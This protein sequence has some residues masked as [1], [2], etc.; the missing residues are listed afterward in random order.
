LHDTAIM[1]R[2]RRVLL[3]THAAETLDEE[4]YCEDR[5][6]CR[7]IEYLRKHHWLGPDVYLAHCVHL[8]DA[9]I[10]LLA[11]TRTAVAHCPSSNMRLGSG[12]PPIRK[13]LDCGVTVG[14][15]VDG[16][17]SNDGG[18]LVREAR[19]SMLLQRVV[20]GPTAVTPAEAFSLGTLGGAT[21]LNRA[22]LGNVAVGN[23]A[24]LAMFR[25][26]DIAF[27]GSM[28][29]DPLGALILCQAPR[30]ER[31]VV[32]G[33]VVVKDGRI[34]LI[35]QDRLVANFNELVGKRFSR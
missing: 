7:P 16:S 17:S 12:V 3:H 2:E 9:E 21:V 6:H 8:N 27:A 28:V 14:L 32:N 23:P 34:A 22:E 25:T 29:Q 18:S 19:Q 1:A 31:V 15:G 13:L 24:D 26:D 20:H 33:R 5:F 30:P 4:K 10:D 35:D 11:K